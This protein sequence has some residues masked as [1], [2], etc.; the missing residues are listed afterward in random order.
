MKPIYSYALLAAFAAVGSASAVEAVTTPV[1][2][3]TIDVPASADTNFTPSLELPQVHSAASTSIAGDVVGA[4]GL[5]SGAFVNGGANPKCYL[6]VTSGS[7]VGRTYPITAND[8]TTITV[9]G[10][11]TDLQTQGFSS[12]NTFKVVPYWTLSTLL[13]GGAGVGSTSDALN[14]NS[15]VFTNENTVTGANRAI[16]KAYF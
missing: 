6:Q 14:P 13:P 11:A 12:G 15:F 7:L 2:Y 16:T 1:G 10:G 5:T 9:D 8:G 3:M 4:A